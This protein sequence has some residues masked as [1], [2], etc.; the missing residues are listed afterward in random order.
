MSKLRQTLLVY[1]SQGLTKHVGRAALFTYVRAPGTP[2]TT[3]K[4]EENSLQFSGSSRGWLEEKT[5]D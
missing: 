4:E 1:D 5:Q 3:R 2:A